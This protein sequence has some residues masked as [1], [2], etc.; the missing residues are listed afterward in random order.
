MK[1]L[2]ISVVVGVSYIEK[3]FER[4]AGI[5]E[6]L[7]NTGSASCGRSVPPGSQITLGLLRILSYLSS[8]LTCS[9]VFLLFGEQRTNLRLKWRTPDQ[10][11]IRAQCN[12][13]PCKLRGSKAITHV[14]NTIRNRI[15]CLMVS[16]DKAKT[17]QARRFLKLLYKARDSTPLECQNQ[18]R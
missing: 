10:I 17:K 3:K 18:K 1:D 14:P 7:N 8:T 4:H 5:M 11:R 9:D 12:A 15:H 13:R 16:L 6:L 2:F